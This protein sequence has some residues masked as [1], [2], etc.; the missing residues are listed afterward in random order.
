VLKVETYSAMET[1]RGGRRMEIRALRP[2]DRL[3][4]IPLVVIP[5]VDNPAP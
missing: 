4:G 3:V 1:L 2:N 5:T